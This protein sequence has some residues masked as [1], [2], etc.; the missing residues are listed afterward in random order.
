[1][2]ADSFS[3]GKMKRPYDQVDLTK[4]AWLVP[5]KREI[6]VDEREKDKKRKTETEVG[7]TR[8]RRRR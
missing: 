7:C 4:L 1:M 8:R 2:V 6:L 5:K 3:S